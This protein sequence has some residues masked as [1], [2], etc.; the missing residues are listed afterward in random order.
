MVFLLLILP[1][2]LLILYIPVILFMVELIPFLNLIFL[3]LWILY[4]NYLLL[5]V[6]CLKSNF[7][8]FNVAVIYRRPNSSLSHFLDDFHSISEFLYSQSIPFY[9]FDDFNISF[10]EP[11]DFYVSKFL[12]ILSIKSFS[13]LQLSYPKTW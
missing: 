1:G 9:I 2:S 5:N 4:S 11:N 12:Q 8:K 6:S 7:S 10:N 13:T 3:F